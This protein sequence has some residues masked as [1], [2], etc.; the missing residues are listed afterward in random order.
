M[1]PNEALPRLLDLSTV[2]DILSFETLIE[3]LRSRVGSPI[4][5][6]NMAC[7]RKKTYPDGLEVRKAAAYLAAIDLRK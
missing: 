3:T 6:V 1:E 4:S 7:G 2:Q 5:Y